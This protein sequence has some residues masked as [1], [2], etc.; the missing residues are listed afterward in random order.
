M[1]KE[2]KNI[3]IVEDEIFASKYLLQIL[4][5]LGFEN[6]D[7]T[8]NAKDALKIVKSKKI[9]M[10]FMDINIEGPKDGIQCAQMLDQ[11]YFIPVIF[12]T[13]YGDEE[14]IDEATKSNAY[15]Y[16]VK[17]FE[18]NDVRA[19]LNVVK[20]LIRTQNELMNKK[21]KQ[22]YTDQ[23]DLSNKQIYNLSTKTLT[24]DN[25]HIDLTA[26]ELSVLDYLCN[27]K[28]QN[29]SYDILK[30]AVWDDSNISNSTIRDTVSR[31]KKKIPDLPL[32]NIINYGYVLKYN[33]S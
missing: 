7:E 27:N 24:V 18:L 30:T 21:E 14:T 23:I 4:Q 5:S 32:E 9:D 19:V 17:P 1:I 33:K 6:I 13:A 10:V 15:G 28:N 8:T 20:R 11:E 2:F 29:I 26:K 12:T 3:L 25:K 22:T 16:L 31:L